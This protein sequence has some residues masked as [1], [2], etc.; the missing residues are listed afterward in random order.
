[1]KEI[2]KVGLLIVNSDSFLV[3]R[4][5]GTSVFLIPGGRHEGTEND[6]QA[7]ERE[8][9][10]ELDCGLEIGTLSYIGD[11]VDVAANEPNSYIKVKLYSG[12]ISGEP[13]ASSE[14]EELKWFNPN[15]DDPQILAPSIRNKILPHV[16]K[17]NLV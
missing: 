6:T 1:M 11:F 13:L 14:I 4:K 17:N 7:L 3:T 2:V 9:R 5:R 12:K 16:V 8:I 10:E 15:S